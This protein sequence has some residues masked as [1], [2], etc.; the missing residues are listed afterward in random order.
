MQERK[1]ISKKC[2]R[3]LSYNTINIDKCLFCRRKHLRDKEN[4]ITP[5]ET[6][7]RQLFG[8]S[9]FFTIKHK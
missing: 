5:E 7:L 3:H 9:R 1:T 8:E 4:S 2:R 6:L